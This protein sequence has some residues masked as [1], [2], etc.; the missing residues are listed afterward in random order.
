MKKLLFVVVIS[1]LLSA[2]ENTQRYT[3]NSPEIETVKAI[4]KDYNAKNY[5]SVV[6]H[7]ADTANVYFNSSTSFKASKLPDYHSETD[8]NFSSRGFVKEGQEFEMV[9]TDKGITWV[10]FWGSWEGTFAANGKKT[11]LQ[12]HLTLQ[13]IDGKVVTEYGYWDASGIVL[14][15][16]EIEENHINK[17]IIQSAY[18]LFAKGEVPAFLALLDPKVE[19]NEAENFIYASK[20][21]YKGIDA[22]VK[23]VFEP[24]GAEWEYWKLTNLQLNQMNNGQVLAT[25]RYKAKHKETGKKLNAQMA[26]VWT[27][28]NGK[29][30][31]F[32]QYTDTKQASEVIK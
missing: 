31:K 20:R 9:V 29:V 16:Q 3:Q 10:N 28:K 11:T 17:Q 23:G 25:G 21:P 32:Q 12:I 30:T 15:M 22:T 1:V 26:H 24:I 4:I 13:F 18:D 19:W 8:P 6:S 7:F 27:L 5:E 2:C 14:A